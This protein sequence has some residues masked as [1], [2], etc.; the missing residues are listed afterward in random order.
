[1]LNDAYAMNDLAKVEE[2]LASL[3]GGGGFVA[4]SEQV[5]DK[6]KLRVHIRELRQKIE[7]LAVHIENI[8]ENESWQLVVLL[9]GDYEAYFREQEAELAEEMAKLQQQFRE[10]V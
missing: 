7:E 3:E 8:K 6:E 1:M 4:A 2:I 10:M 9:G 5:A